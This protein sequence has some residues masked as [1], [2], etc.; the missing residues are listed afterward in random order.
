M[1]ISTQF[2]SKFAS[3]PIAQISLSCGACVVGLGIFGVMLTQPATAQESSNNPQE[4]FTNQ[5]D[6]DPLTDVGGLDFNDLIHRA[7]VGIPDVEQFNS[8][9]QK[10]YNS[11]IEE[12]RR[13]RSERLG[14]PEQ[15]SPMQTETQN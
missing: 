4:I 1:K 7:Q 14:N 15:I 6:R 3:K 8:Q 10:N 13:Q 5:N 9:Q 11:A 2:V 12:F